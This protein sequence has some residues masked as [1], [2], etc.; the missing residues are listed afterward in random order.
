MEETAAYVEIL[1]SMTKLGGVER[2]VQEVAQ[3]MYQVELSRLKTKSSR[4]KLDR[5]MKKLKKVIQK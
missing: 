5:A 2:N 4:Q 3:V 1:K